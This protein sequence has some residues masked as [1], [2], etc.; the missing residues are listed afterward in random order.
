M[1]SFLYWIVLAV[2]YVAGVLTADQVKKYIPFV[3]K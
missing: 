2:A 1:E 3:S